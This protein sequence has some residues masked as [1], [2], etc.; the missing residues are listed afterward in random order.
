MDDSDAFHPFLYDIDFILG[1]K[2][3][4]VERCDLQY[5]TAEAEGMIGNTKRNRKK[6]TSFVP[7]PDKDKKPMPPKKKT[8]AAKKTTASSRP[9]KPLGRCLSIKLMKT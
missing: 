5:T 7:S 9:T 3:A 8:T 1:G 4:G 2:V 6:N